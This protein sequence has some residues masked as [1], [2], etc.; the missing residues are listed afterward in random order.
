MPTINSFL[1][2][3]HAL[4]GAGEVDVYINEELL[5]EN[6]AYKGMSR[7]LPIGPGNN[8]IQVFAASSKTNPIL[9][10]EVELPPSSVITLAIIGMVSE[11]EVLPIL[12]PV[13]DINPREVEIRFVHL[14]PDAP[15]L[16]LVLNDNSVF[17]SVGYKQVTDYSVIAPGEHNVQLRPSDDLDIILAE[18]NLVFSAGKAY[19][20]YGVGLNDG[21][22]GLEI[23]YFEDGPPV[24]ENKAVPKKELPPKVSS[25]NK[26]SVK[27]VITYV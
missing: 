11:A 27:I 2:V 16:N 25:R 14:S 9:D 12:Q 3:L 18:N 5:E 21:T 15:T 10:T 23:I 24:L 13:N 4:P 8:R 22:P 1:E 6:L 20:I 7:F 19:T 26:S 17:S